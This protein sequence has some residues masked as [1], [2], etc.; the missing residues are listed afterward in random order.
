LEDLTSL[1]ITDGYI[2]TKRKR[3]L[4]S[5]F[6]YYFYMKYGAKAAFDVDYSFN[7]NASSTIVSGTTG[8]VMLANNYY[9]PLCKSHE[10]YYHFTHLDAIDSLQ[11]LVIT[12]NTFQANPEWFFQRI[13]SKYNKASN[14]F[15]F[16]NLVLDL[17]GNEGGDRRLLNILYQMIAGKDVYD[18]SD[19]YVRAKNIRETDNLIAIN[20][21][22]NSTEAV[23]NAEDYLEKHFVN[24]NNDQFSSDTKNWYDE[25][26]LDFDVSDVEF[27]GQVY[28]L[29]SGKTFSA[30]ADLGR[31]L[32][33]LDN[34]IL[35]GEETGG[36]HIG[37]TANMLLKYAL[38]NSKVNIQIPV[39]YEKFINI[40]MNV[41]TGR[42]TFPD[43]FITQSFEDLVNK[44][45]AVFDF[46]VNLI[47]QN[48]SM[49]SN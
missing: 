9:R 15:D 23:T 46:T 28:V 38:P 47:E 2:E 35:V 42:G 30:A 1:T 19:T 44:R 36:A 26:K 7:E 24:T 22:F 3:E 14:Q 16:Q 12:L 31:I 5:K 34:V 25:F 49:G 29:T 37:R 43:Y 13:S 41:N 20:G 27:N 11:T 40:D 4:E 45:D 39:I 8:N 21:T 18:P 33:D 17:R 10:R 48:S 32:G 6:G